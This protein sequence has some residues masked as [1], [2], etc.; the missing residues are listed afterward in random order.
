MAKIDKTHQTGWGG[1]WTEQKL[2]CFTR[3]VRAYLTIMNA[4][5]ENTIG[6]SSTLTALPVVVTARYRQR[7]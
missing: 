6:S 4:Y 3:Y 7:V 2:D 5:R 1:P